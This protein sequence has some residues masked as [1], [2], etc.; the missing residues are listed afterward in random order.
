MPG[1]N[2]QNQYTLSGTKYDLDGNVLTD[3]FNTYTWDADGHVSTINSSSCGTNGVCLTY[4][5][6]GQMVEKSSNS[7]FT[8]VLYSPA[9]KTAIMA[10]QTA[11]FV[12]AAAGRGH[13]VR[14]QRQHAPHLAQ[15]TGWAAE[16]FRRR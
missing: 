11:E 8:E 9:G 12:S 6:L 13:G 5:A 7:N 16:G 1:Y 10:G 14:F 2:N 15:G 3:A 4:E